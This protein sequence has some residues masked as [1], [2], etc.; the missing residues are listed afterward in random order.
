MLEQL[1][2]FEAGANVLARCSRLRETLTE[3]TKRNEAMADL[4]HHISLNLPAGVAA[5]ADVKTPAK[6]ASRVKAEEL[7]EFS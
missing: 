7:G 1:S 4:A 6:V 5:V 3:S 2:E